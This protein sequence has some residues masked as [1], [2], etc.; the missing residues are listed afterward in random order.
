MLR[1]PPLAALVP[2]LLMACGGAKSVAEKPRPR[3]CGGDPCAGRRDKRLGHALFHGG[4]SGPIERGTPKAVQLFEATLKTLLLSNAASMFELAKLYNQAQAPREALALPNEQW[5]RTRRTSGTA[6]CS[7]L[8][9]PERRYTGAT[10]AHCDIVAKWSDRYEVYFGLASTLA[11]QKKVDETRQVYRNL[12]S[13]WEQCEELVMRE[14]DARHRRQTEAA[15]DL[16]TDAIA[17]HPEQTQYYDDTAEVHETLGD[18]A[19]AE[20]LYKRR[21]RWTRTTA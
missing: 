5:R 8:S 13:G 9:L 4:Q 1:P 6:S 10:K 11:Q 21:W 18:T 2:A 7:D 3:R 12:E 16:L 14:Y 17:K 20:E 15:R 19:K